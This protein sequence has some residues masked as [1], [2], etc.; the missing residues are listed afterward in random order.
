MRAKI[1]ELKQANIAEIRSY[2]DPPAFVGEVMR[3]TFLLLDE[4]HSDMQQWSNIRL[5][6]GKM[7]KECISN[8][9]L[10]CSPLSDLNEKTI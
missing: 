1:E 9:F 6:L 3:A 4:S 2:P 5:L 7:G 8:W 10:T